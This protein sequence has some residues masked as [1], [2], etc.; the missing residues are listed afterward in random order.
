MDARMEQE[1]SA[2]A[3]SAAVQPLR[4][5]RGSPGG[6]GQ[7]FFA[8][9]YKWARV[10]SGVPFFKYGYREVEL[11]LVTMTHVLIDGGRHG[12]IDGAAEPDPPTEPNDLFAIN[13][14][15]ARNVASGVQGTGVNTSQDY[16]TG[17]NHLPLGGAEADAEAEIG[18]AGDCQNLVVVWLTPA[19]DANGTRYHWFQLSNADYGSCG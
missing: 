6:A 2:L 16:P 1:L 12:D 8:E 14:V 11:D 18:D 9:L 17:F 13:P 19:Y 10:E 5:P 15:E 3:A 7:G 4:R